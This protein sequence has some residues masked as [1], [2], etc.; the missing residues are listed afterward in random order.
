MIMVMSLENL[1]KN[2]V[3]FNILFLGMLCYEN[4]V[5]IYFLIELFL[6]II[7]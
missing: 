1:I 2:L 7:I 3:F 4:I 6:L 5:C